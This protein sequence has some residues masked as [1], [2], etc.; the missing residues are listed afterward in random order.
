MIVDN[1]I[2]QKLQEN[3]YMAFLAI[4]THRLR[5]ILTTLGVVIGVGA[6]V[7]LISL[8]HGLNRSVEEQFRSIGTNLISIN[9]Y[10]WVMTGSSWQYRNRKDLTLEDAEAVRELCPSVAAVAPCVYTARSIYYRDKST[11]ALTVCGTTPEYQD[12]EN[13]WVRR[14]RFITYVD[15]QRSREV[16]VLGHDVLDRLFPFED[17]LD[18]MVKIGNHRFR[19][20]G[21]LEEKGDIVGHGQDNIVDIPIS[22]FLKLFG[23]Y[24]SV[25]I[26]AQAVS[27]E[28]FERA[29]DEIRHV[30][31]RQRKVPLGG[32]DDFAINTSDELMERFRALTGVAFAAMVGVGGL[33]LLV[34]GI[35]IMNIMLVSVMERTREIGIRKA[36]GARRHDI[37][38]Q[39]LVE[40]VTLCTVGGGLGVLL[41]IG[42]AKFVAAVSPLPAAVPPWSIALGFTFSWIVGLISGIYPATRASRQDPIEILHY[43]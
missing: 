1:V 41:G 43:E 13:Y 26:S 2:L 12:I 33:S 22:T 37:L 35:G 23:A 7:S 20:V 34:G 18:K 11:G 42:V 29:I 21:I 4:S 27:E 16:V 30:L 6:V 5:S 14:G 32:P 17:P 39:F 36:L 19:V 15:V 40:A 28:V 9:K 10:P 38:L 3:L 8:V 31:R 24:R 25:N